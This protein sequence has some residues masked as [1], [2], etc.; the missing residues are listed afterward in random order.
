VVQTCQYLDVVNKLLVV[1]HLVFISIRQRSGRPA[2]FVV[3]SYVT[4]FA[5]I[6]PPGDKIPAIWS[7]FGSVSIHIVSLDVL[8]WDQCWL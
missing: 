1:M 2:V 5:V 8:G 3:A 4:L 6:S 7:F